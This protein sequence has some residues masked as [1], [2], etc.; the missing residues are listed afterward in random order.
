MVAQANQLPQQV[1]R[2]LQQLR[3]SIAGQRRPRPGQAP[4]PLSLA[5]HVRLKFC[6]RRGPKH[7]VAT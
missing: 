2:L 5:L 7:P 3:K 4:G 1:L 6:R